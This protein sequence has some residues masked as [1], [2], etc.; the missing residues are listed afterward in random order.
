MASISGSPHPAPGMIEVDHAGLV[1][2][3]ASA[4]ERIEYG[5]RMV[6]RAVMREPLLVFVG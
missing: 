2:T 1:H 6:E 5:Q 4:R 3:P